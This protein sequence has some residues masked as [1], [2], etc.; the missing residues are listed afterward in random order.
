MTI[1]NVTNVFALDPDDFACW[2]IGY[3]YSSL[4]ATPYYEQYVLNNC[5]TKNTTVTFNESDLSY[6]TNGLVEKCEQT[7]QW[8]RAGRIGT[9][10]WRKIDQR[11]VYYSISSQDV[12]NFWSPLFESNLPHI[13]LYGISPTNYTTILAGKTCDDFSKSCGQEYQ[14][15][16]QEC[17]NNEANIAEWD[18]INCQGICKPKCEWVN[19]NNLFP[20]ECTRPENFGPPCE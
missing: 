20:D 10:L 2:I 1:N 17:G 9:Y 18:N 7:V 3:N 15:K 13:D 16:I 19:A 8:T 11:W 5:W 12:S 6:H 4:D 14:D